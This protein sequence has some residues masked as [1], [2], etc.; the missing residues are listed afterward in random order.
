MKR[1][2]RRMDGVAEE[3]TK[4]VE[5]SKLVEPKFLTLT[6]MPA[7]QVAFKVVRDDKPGD[8]DMTGNTTAPEPARRR[9]IRSTQRSSLLF[10]EFP[11]GATDEDVAKI[12]EEYG[13]D[14]YEVVCTSDGRKCLKRSDLAELPKD[15]VT[16]MIGDGRKA[17][18]QR[19][20]TPATTD[21]MPF[22]EVIAVEFSH[23]KFADEG[24]VMDYLQRYDIDFLEKGVENTDKLIRVTRSGLDDLNAEV[25][26]VEVETG[27]V[28]VVTRSATEDT[29][30]T[31][32]KFTEVVCEEC[33]G[34][35]GW[36]QLD[37]NAIMADVEFCNAADDA[38]YRLRN[39]VD[40]ILFYSQLPV[41]ARKDLVT[42]AC[43]QFSAYIGALLDGL[44]AK[45]VL[46][47]RSS[48]ESKESN[49][50]P[51]PQKITPAPAATQTEDAGTSAATPVSDETPITRS[52]IATLIADGIAAALAAQTKAPVVDGE[53]PVESV[54]RGDDEPKGDDA[55]S[56]IA[57]SVDTVAKTVDSVVSSVEAL[58]KRMDTLAGSTTLRSDGR[59]SDV[60]EPTKADVFQG[61]FS[62][63][64]VR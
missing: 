56:K 44:P 18:V 31:Q 64:R 34:Q 15:A 40:S 27:V 14:D 5:V 24:A 38:T 47:N 57:A 21:P 50:M 2:V 8:V 4:P 58:A 33:Y 39:L 46:V 29:S 42:R 25:R 53:P 26:R 45:V 23:D 20:E 9:R 60:S 37:F 22:V 55:V 1:V 12:A 52:E 13:L 54:A 36:G 43:S 49:A 16:V 32:S 19:A 3:V 10:I 6:K 59:D 28:A 48:L 62:A 51:M 61:I 11:E 7:N 41:A 17:G 35:W 30:L 63:N